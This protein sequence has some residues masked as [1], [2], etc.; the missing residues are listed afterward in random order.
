MILEIARVKEEHALELQASKDAH[1]AALLDEQK[2][3]GVDVQ[4]Q[5]TIEMEYFDRP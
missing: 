5:T 1:E 4:V 2:A 3:V